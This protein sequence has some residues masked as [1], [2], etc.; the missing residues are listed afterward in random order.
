MSDSQEPAEQPKQ[1]KIVIDIPRE[2]KAAYANVAVI[3]HTAVE[4]VFDFA[5]VLPRTPR[6]AQT[7]PAAPGGAD[8]RS[9]C[10]PQQDLDQSDPL[11]VA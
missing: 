11:P 10:L 1:H 8:R 6:R 4:I 2:L 7:R 9:R 3:S 5:Q